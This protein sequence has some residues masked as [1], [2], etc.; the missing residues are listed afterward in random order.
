V[1]AGR[2]EFKRSPASE[3][4]VAA[5]FVELV[6]A[7]RL[8]GYTLYGLPDQL[9]LDGVF[10]FALTRGPDAVYDQE[11]NPLGVLFRDGRTEVRTAGRSIAS[12]AR[13]VMRSSPGT[14]SRTPSSH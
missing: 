5:E 9:Q 10:D 14:Q 4:E 3:R 8:K 13:S 6:Q 12:R 11:L 2:R 7:D 1:E